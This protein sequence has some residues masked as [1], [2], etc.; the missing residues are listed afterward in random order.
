MGSMTNP[1]DGAAEAALD[2]SETAPHFH[3]TL[4]QRLRRWVLGAAYALRPQRLS[5]L[6]RLWWFTLKYYLTPKAERDKLPDLPHFYSE[7]GLVGISNDLSV[8]TLVA[9]YSRGFFPVCHIGPMKWWCP[10]ERAVIDPAD[11]HVSKNTRRLLRQHRFTVTMDKDFAGVMEGCA[12]PRPGKVPLTWLTPRVMQAF[13]KAYEAGFAHSVEVWDEEGRLVGGVFGITIGKVYFGESKFSAVRGASKLATAVLDR[14]LVAWG[15]HLCDAKWMT[16]DL[17]SLGYKPMERDDFRSLIQWYTEEPGHA[18][19]WDVDPTLD[20]T[21][22][23]AKRPDATPAQATAPL[24]V[25]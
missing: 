9:N 17:A 25:A 24:R 2:P 14:H 19:R 4:M 1:R 16:S 7:R 6:P 20:L 3:E 15:Y 18:G 11:I 23:P 5:L 21:D 22:W 12:R 13:W 8:P 10:E